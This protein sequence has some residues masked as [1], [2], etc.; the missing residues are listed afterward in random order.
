MT[1][2]TMMGLMLMMTVQ[3]QGYFSGG[4]GYVL[5]QAAVKRFVQVDVQTPLI[6][7]DFEDG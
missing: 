7:Y 4:A 3:F 6:E 5:S 1:I 2:M